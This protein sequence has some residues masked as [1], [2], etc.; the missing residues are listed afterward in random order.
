MKFGIPQSTLA[1]GLSG[2]SRCVPSRPTGHPIL[3]SVNLS[4][5][6]NR[7]T[8]IAFNLSQGMKITLTVEGEEDGSICL[9]ARLLNDI[10]AKLEGSH[11]ELTTNEEHRCLIKTASGKFNLLGLPTDEFP[12]LPAFS[13]GTS[14]AISLSALQTGIR[15]TVWASS[16]DETKQVLTGVLVK[17]QENRL[18]CA[19]TDGHRLARVR[20]KTEGAAQYSI[21]IPRIAVQ[22]LLRL[23]STTGNDT[24]LNLALEQ[25]SCQFSWEHEGT[26]YAY[27]SRVLDG[28]YPHYE[29]LIPT[30][31]STQVVVNRTKLYEALERVEVISEA[32]NHV[33]KVAL[34]GDQMVISGEAQDVG[35]GEERLG[36][37]HEGGNLTLAFNAQYVLQC[38]KSYGGTDIR[39]SMN[40]P[41][42]P[43]VFEPVGEDCLYLCM[44]VQIRS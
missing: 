25:T 44:P 43:M 1:Y 15:N 42:S 12:S 40:T 4:L 2:I 37:S 31:F 8:L 41:A 38:L 28:Q 32:K 17:S 34:V 23:L 18:E 14:I 6:G 20:V 19:A 9:P 5:K 16:T 33:V 39:I 27:T 21:V 22:D 29:M 35:Q 11:I 3:S 24:I 10:V 36:I 30:T 26:E 13:P 7:L